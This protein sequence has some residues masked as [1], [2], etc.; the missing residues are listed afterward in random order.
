MLTD[1]LVRELDVRKAANRGVTVSGSV[2]LAALRRLGGALASSEGDAVVEF[3]F[4]RDEERRFVVQLQCR[5]SLP[6]PCQRCLEPMAVAVDN[7]ADLAI[8]ASDEQASQLPKSLE[9]W[10]V[11]QD[12]ADLWAL[13]EDELILALPFTSYHPVDVCQPRATWQEP[14]EPELEQRPNPFNVLEQLKS[15]K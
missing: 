8:V 14:P 15:G 10:L 3:R 9:P 4:S 6:V 11:E 13:V 5:A 12:S 2:P 1:P 7:S